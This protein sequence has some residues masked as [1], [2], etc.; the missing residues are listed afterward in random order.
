MK[1]ITKKRVLIFLLLIALGVV[2]I[3]VHPITVRIIG[4]VLFIMTLGLLIF[5]R[6][7]DEI[8][9]SHIGE[10]IIGPVRVNAPIETEDGI[11]YSHGEEEFIV[12]SATTRRIQTTDRISEL[13]DV[14]GKYD[15]IASESLPLEQNG[16]EQLNFALEKL[17]SIIKFVFAAHSVI[18]FWYNKKSA[19]LS[20]ARYVSVSEH[21]LVNTK[22]DVEDDLISR[23]VLKGEPSHFNSLAQ[24]AETDNIRYYSEPQGIRSAIGVPIYYNDQLIASLVVDSKESDGYGVE[25]VYELGRFVR[26][27]TILLNLF[28]ERYTESISGRRLKGAMQFMTP[29]NSI[30]NEKDIFRI[31][32]ESLSYMVDFD[33]FAFVYYNE[34]LDNYSITDIQHNVKL[35]YVG[36]GLE[37]EIKNTL[38]GK[39]IHGKSHVLIDDMSMI[40]QKRFN[41]IEDVTFDGSFLCIPLVYQNNVYGALCFDNLRKHS[42]G[43]DDLTYT[44]SI[45][46][47]L[48]FMLYSYTIQKTLKSHGAFDFDTNL[49]NRKM[50]RKLLAMELEKNNI[51]SIPS[52]LLLLRVDDFAEQE[53]LFDE[54]P[55]LTVVQTISD[56]L[57]KES[58]STALKARIS[59]SII[60]VHYFNVTANDMYLVADKLRQRIARMS[61]ST[62]PGKTSFTVSIGIASCTGRT[63][64]DEV[65]ENAQLALEWAI[66]D[67]GNKVTNMN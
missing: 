35:Q 44:K 61:F 56:L 53:N 25:T 50:F 19:K 27:I 28:E 63:S 4:V 47:V 11:K 23:V 2:I 37:V 58:P 36:E 34:D 52:T 62:L 67:G 16:K 3:L 21:I 59:E 39:A 49:L 32:K 64:L 9:D 6:N 40:S 13:E 14:K 29:I 45:A 33:A 46:S 66:K 24:N 17:L 26:L 30:K 18:M 7:P 54:S 38:V 15:E 1:G 41:P 8:L 43:K 12:K 5:S 20:I 31:V 22:F 65:F 48:S 42:Y 60:A 51:I 10:P 57:E 55:L